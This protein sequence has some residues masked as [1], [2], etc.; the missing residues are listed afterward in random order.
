MHPQKF[1]GLKAANILL[2]LTVALK[3]SSA[4]VLNKNDKNE[5]YYFNF[6]WKGI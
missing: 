1:S 4:I 2:G 3:S 6:P 5:K